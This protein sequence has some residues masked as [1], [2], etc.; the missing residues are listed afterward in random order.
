MLLLATV[1]R[2]MDIVNLAVDNFDTSFRNDVNQL[3]DASSVSRDWARREDNG[4]AGLELYLTVGSVGDTRE[5][6][7]RLTLTTCTE[8]QNLACRVVFDFIWLDK[9]SLRS[10]DVAKLDSVDNG[11]FHRTTKDSDLAPSLNS[12]FC[13]LL[14]TEDI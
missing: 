5:G 9:G 8:D 11:L 14:E 13:C 7:H 6:C 12:S 4:I 10:F 1:S 2:C 3:V